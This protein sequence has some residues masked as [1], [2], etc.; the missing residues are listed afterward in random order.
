MSRPL[1]VNPLHEE[2]K[3]VIIPDRAGDRQFID[4]DRRQPY[5]ALHGASSTRPSARPGAIP[6]YAAA[7][8]H[9]L[10]RIASNIGRTHQWHD[11]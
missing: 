7:T 10:G 1:S 6:P 11:P 8:R 5:L 9:D 2:P 4:N 3:R